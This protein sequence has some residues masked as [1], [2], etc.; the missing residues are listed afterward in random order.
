MILQPLGL[1]QAPRGTGDPQ[2]GYQT[3]AAGGVMVKDLARKDL[4][5]GKESL[6]TIVAVT[7]TLIATV[8]LYKD[9]FSVLAKNASSRQWGLFAQDVLFAVIFLALIYGNLVYQLARVGYLRRLRRHLKEEAEDAPESCFLGETP[10]PVT[11]LIPSYKEEPHII[12]QALLSAALQDYP[13]RR[14]V[15]LIDDPPGPT[16]PDELLKLEAAKNLPGELQKLLD[17]EAARYRWAY[18]HFL[19]RSEE[20]GLIDLQKELEV[21]SELYEGA[22][23]WFCR[24]ATRYQVEDHTDDLFVSL[25]FTQRTKTLRNRARELRH[26]GAGLGRSRGWEELLTGYR[27][28]ASLFEVELTSFERKEY[29]NL[30]W[31]SNKAMNLNSYIGLMGKRFHCVE[32][33][34]GLYL[35]PT[36]SETA[37]LVVP[38]TKFI[39]TLDADSLLAPHYVKR[40]V[41]I[42][43]APGNERLAVAQ[44]P[45]TA[46][47]SP[48]G[49]LERI[50]GATTDIQYIIHQG[51]TQADGTYWVG[52]NALLRKEALDDIVTY[53]QERGF[54]IAKYI[55]DRTVIEDT[56]S[57]VDLLVRGWTLYNLPERLSYSATPCDF[58]SLLIQRQRWAN[59]GLIILPKLLRHLLRTPHRLRT[60]AEGFMRVNYL[61]SIAS[62]NLGLLL[63]LTFHADDYENIVWLPLT[64]LPY[65]WIYGR[66]MVL[67]G[68][69]IRDLFRVYALNF[70]LIPVNLAGVFKSIQQ[71]VTGKQIPF[72]RTPKVRGRT[73]VP[74]GYLWAGYALMFYCFTLG[75]VDI[76]ESRWFHAFFA[77]GSAFVLLYAT[78]AFIGFRASWEDLSL[79]LMKWLRR[80]RGRPYFRPSEVVLAME[81][82]VIS[83]KPTRRRWPFAARIMVLVLALL[84]NGAV[85]VEPAPRAVPVLTY[86][87]ITL[88]QKKGDDE[89]INI[90]R[91][92]EQMRY[93]ADHGYH[94]LKV[95]ELIDFM[96]GRRDLPERSIVLTFDDGWKSVLDA[97]PVLDRYEFKVSFS[98]ITACA[99]GVLGGKDDYMTWGKIAQL[100]R[101]PNFEFG[102][103]TVT[104]PWNPKDN[105]VS[106]IEGKNPGK[107]EDQVRLELITSKVT[108][109]SRLSRPIR[110][111]TWPCGWY[112]Q[113]LIN[114]ATE[115]GYEA[116][117]TTDEGTNHQ[118][119]DVR[120]IKRFVVDGAWDLKRFEK[121]LREVQSSGP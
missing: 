81:G 21:L 55:Q 119:D 114:M 37:D 20:E 46:V 67:S 111:L 29:L 100:A 107:G 120:F 70:L 110:F 71:A 38:E 112:N 80:D 83:D 117:L 31:A 96:K 65:Y 109:E 57:S 13:V 63:I 8:L 104:H 34:A 19:A 103:H 24:Q 50:A 116:M 12:R 118:G 85:A 58:G 60:W 41:Q 102:S 25:T 74:P 113:K 45:Y 1:R 91:F 7:I 108:L 43:L 2:P 10:P 76:W 72:S 4:N 26:F 5:L 89:T 115:A 99:D 84:L 66:D 97:V 95:S 53:E 59:G 86:H 61:S 14:V 28:L 94:T 69:R 68:Y 33:E 105:L 77:L 79:P 121:F 6:Y 56:E 75:L 51:F 49:L 101:N 16:D 52:A 78:S 36:T 17:A 30:S 90:E 106:W 35:Q 39:V 88:E 11:I 27:H 62:T 15:L 40:L 47:P 73:T 82:E 9:V 98:I 44:T 18:A 64:A 92:A 3:R 23:D 22:A 54:T 32:G 93:L 42:M 87:K 48:K